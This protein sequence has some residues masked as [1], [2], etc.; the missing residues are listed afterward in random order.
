MFLHTSY[1]FI[2]ALAKET[3]L[4]QTKLNKNKQC[5]FFEIKQDSVSL[6]G[7]SLSDMITTVLENYGHVIRK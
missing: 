2:E 7:L 5:A 1:I 3:K 6:P 4:S